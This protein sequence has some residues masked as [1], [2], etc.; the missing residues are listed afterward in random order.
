MCHSTAQH[1]SSLLAVLKHT[2]FLAYTYTFNEGRHSMVLLPLPRLIHYSR[3]S[4]RTAKL[5]H[6]CKA[7]HELQMLQ[8]TDSA[9]CAR[10]LALSGILCSTQM[11]KGQ[12]Q[13]DIAGPQLSASKKAL[14]CM[15]G[16]S[17]KA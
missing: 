14:Q 10:T 9:S 12:L 13:P 7:L 4:P 8:S 1:H 11:L 16:N 3:A 2:V 5:R 15:H 6:L 17:S